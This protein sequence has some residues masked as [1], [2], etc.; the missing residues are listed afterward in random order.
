MLTNNKLTIVADSIIDEERIASFGAIMNLE[1]M[2]L[3]M[4]SRYINK[5]ACKLHKDIV[6]A[7]QAAFED[8]AYSIQDMLQGVNSKEVSEE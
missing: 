5:D 2:E 8:H 3:H 4:T 1:T 6:R 7:D